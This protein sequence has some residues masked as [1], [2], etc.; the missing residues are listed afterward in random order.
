M[1]H[2]HTHT[3]M[4]THT[5]THTHS[6]AS[7]K[8]E[9]GEKGRG[10]EGEGKGKGRGRDLSASQ[11]AQFPLCTQTSLTAVSVCITPT[12]TSSASCDWVVHVRLGESLSLD[13]KGNSRMKR[14]KQSTKLMMHK[15]VPT[16]PT[17]CNNTHLVFCCMLYVYY[18]QRKTL[19]KN[20]ENFVQDL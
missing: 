14:N 4:H 15:E 3:H 11:P 1:T 19:I 18:T 13:F 10:R 6:K 12:H 2:T 5:H 9:R 17:L 16:H 8:A 20:I 7:K